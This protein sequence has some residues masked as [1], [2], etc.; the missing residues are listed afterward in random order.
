MGFGY[1]DIGTWHIAEG[2]P[3]LLLPG[4]QAEGHKMLGPPKKNLGSP[5]GKL[6]ATQWK[7]L[8]HP[9]VKIEEVTVFSIKRPQKAG[10]PGE[11][12]RSEQQRAA[13]RLPGLPKLPK[14]DN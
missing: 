12:W 5:S 13:K 2:D 1:F 8:G 11:S 14:I 9:R 10:T 4:F 7:T 6:W 3:G